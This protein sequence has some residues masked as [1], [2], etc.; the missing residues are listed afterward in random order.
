MDSR[1]SAA[2]GGL[3]QRQERKDKGEVGLQILDQF[4]VGGYQ[5]AAF[6]LGQDHVQAVIDAGPH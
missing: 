6:S 1:A 4:V 2:D 5:L 3:G